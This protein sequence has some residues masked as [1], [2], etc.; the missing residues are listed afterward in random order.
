MQHDKRAHVY[1]QASAH[2]E[3]HIVA[4]LSGLLALRKAV[5]DALN[6]GRGR[7]EVCA[8]DGE[9][10]DVVVH[11]LDSSAD[12][13]RLRLPYDLPGVPSTEEALSP[14]DLP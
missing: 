2:A 1:P 8:G 13:R 7:Q 6:G 11:R 4:D 12:W 3:V 9:C 10:F 5:D 14:W